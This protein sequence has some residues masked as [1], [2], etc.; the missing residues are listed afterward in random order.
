MSHAAVLGAGTWLSPIQEDHRA[1]EHLFALGE[2]APCKWALHSSFTFES[3]VTALQED[4]V[5]II[6]SEC[7]LNPGTWRD[8][9]QYI[10]LFS[11]PPLVIV[12]SRLADE[13]LWAEALNLGAYDVLAKPFNSDEVYRVL[14]SAWRHWANRHELSRSATNR[15]PQVVCDS[16][17]EIME[18]VI[19]SDDE[20]KRLEKEFGPAVRHV[21]TWSSDGVFGYS[22]MPVSILERVANGSN[23]PSLVGA[24]SRLKNS[25]ERTKSFVELLQTF[26]PA[27]IEKIVTAYHECP[28]DSL[29]ASSEK[30]QGPIVDWIAM[31]QS[32]LLDQN[33][34][35]FVEGLEGASHSRGD[36]PTREN[37]LALCFVCLRWASDGPNCRQRYRCDEPPFHGPKFPSW[38]VIGRVVGQGK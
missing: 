5:P 18:V 33:D 28:L 36:A 7:D 10:S 2:W 23:D 12:T 16:R 21:G 9:L 4:R 17:S 19:I 38:S 3:A 13:R 15:T 35:H 1:L 22:S 31:T 20:L 8:L 30:E 6:L 27:L 37:D 32:P 11:D 24:V 14:A 29:R 26:G 25:A 34:R